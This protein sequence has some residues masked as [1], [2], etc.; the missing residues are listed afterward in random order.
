MKKR[1]LQVLVLKAFRHQNPPIIVI[2]D[3][4]Q[5]NN[6]IIFGGLSEPSLRYLDFYRINP[7]Q[8]GQ[9]VIGLHDLVL[10]H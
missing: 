3:S 4:N 7:F 2:Q 6:K 9:A 10:S 8:E 5:S 1:S